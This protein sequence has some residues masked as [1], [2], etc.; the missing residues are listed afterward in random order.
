MYYLEKL[1]AEALLWCFGFKSGEEYQ[2]LLNECFTRNSADDI[3]F[4]LEQCSSDLNDTMSIFFRFYEYDSNAPF[5]VDE[6]GMCLFDG[7]NQAYDSNVFGIDVFGERCYA[8]WNRLPSSLHQIEP[9]WT[10]SYADDCL[11]YNDESQT[12]KL[13]EDAFLYYK[14]H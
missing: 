9:F 13:Y 6:F 5:N 14:N 3:F 10:L 1:Y 2:S 12:R 7:L 8:L 4:Q 11:S